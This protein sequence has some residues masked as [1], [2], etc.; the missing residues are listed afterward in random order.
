MNLIMQALELALQDVML[1]KALENVRLDLCAEDGTH[2]YFQR[3]G[4]E[5]LII[6]V[7]LYCHDFIMIDLWHDADNDDWIRDVMGASY[8]LEPLAV[9]YTY[10]N[11]TNL[12]HQFDEVV[13][14]IRH[15]LVRY[16]FHDKT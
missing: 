12:H 16:A 8:N 11:F 9:W 6:A 3:P 13:S 15:L 2:F 7:D 5:F 4:D 14:V 1:E 10:A